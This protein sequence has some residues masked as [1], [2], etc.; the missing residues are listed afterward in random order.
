MVVAIH[1][2]DSSAYFAYPEEDVLKQ[3]IKN[4]G[5]TNVSLDFLRDTSTDSCIRA[6]ANGKK[7]KCVIIPHT[8][9]I[10]EEIL[11][12]L[13]QG[14]IIILLFMSTMYQN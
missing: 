6:R 12:K 3:H 4:I 14:M 7:K 11:R 2:P 9:Y 10:P 8:P 1:L 13:Y 5:K